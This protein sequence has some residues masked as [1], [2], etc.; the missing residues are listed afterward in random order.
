[1]QRWHQAIRRQTAPHA[2][3][4][5]GPI[6]TLLKFASSV[7]MGYSTAV[8]S[9]KL[10]LHWRT[11]PKPPKSHFLFKRG[12]CGHGGGTGI[13]ISLRLDDIVVPGDSFFGKNRYV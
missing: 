10:F 1:M 12:Q 13:L 2:S 6:E 11:L 5:R 7:A 4:W 8:N 9:L 3:V